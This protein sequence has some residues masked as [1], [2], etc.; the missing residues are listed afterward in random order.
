MTMQVKVE[1]VGRVLEEQ[2]FKLERS[3][4]DEH[5]LEDRIY[6]KMLLSVTFFSTVDTG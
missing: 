6:A 5:E 4:S 2:P 1:K 3:F